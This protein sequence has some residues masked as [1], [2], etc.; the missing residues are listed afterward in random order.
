M[1]KELFV[2]DQ[3]RF[4]VHV[5]DMDKEHQ[6]LIGYMNKL[7]QL[8]N[9]KASTAHLQKAIDDMVK[10][11]LKHF[12]D[13]E[14]YFS[15]IPYPQAEVHKKIHKDLVERLTGHIDAFKKKGHLDEEFFAFLKTWLAAH[16]CGIDRKYGEIGSKKTA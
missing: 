8:H 3:N 12:A 6:V 7:Y 4:S 10:F 14:A 2:W 16:I 15:K 13:E 5:D 11:T 1:S 9:D